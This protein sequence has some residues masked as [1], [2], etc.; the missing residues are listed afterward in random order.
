MTA[1][2]PPH[3]VYLAL[4]SN[5]GDRRVNLAAAVARLPPVVA[6]ERISQL[7]ETE[8]AYVTDQPRFLN[9]VLHGATDL[10]PEELL[11]WIKRLERELGRQSGLRFGPRLI[12]IDILLYDALTLSSP[13]LTIPHPRM[14]E[15][16]FVLVP[17]AEIAPA[18]VPPGW[19][20]SVADTARLAHTHGE[21][22]APTGTLDD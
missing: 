8:P 3:T 1:T 22:I 12:D 11:A 13:A 4:G 17:L 21:I 5:L 7:Y 10:P 14:A 15:R 20:A 18:L 6:V 2:T 9:A 19:N 16:P